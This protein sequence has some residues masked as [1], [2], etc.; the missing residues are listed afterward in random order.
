MVKLDLKCGFQVLAVV[1]CYTL[2]SGDRQWR[3]CPNVE[4]V[5]LIRFSSLQSN[6]INL[7]FVILN[8]LSLYRPPGRWISRK[9]FFVDLIHC[10]PFI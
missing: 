9:V 7:D 3:L 8:Q 5:N 10:R 6:A 4:G 2:G 1:S